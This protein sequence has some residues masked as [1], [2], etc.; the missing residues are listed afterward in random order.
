MLDSFDAE[1]N[2]QRVLTCSG[3]DNSTGVVTVCNTSCSGAPSQ[4]GAP[5][6][7]DPGYGLDPSSAA[8]VYTPVSGQAGVAGCPAGFN[9]IDEGDKTFFNANGSAAAKLCD[10][11]IVRA[12]HH[13]L[14]LLPCGLSTVR[15]MPPLLITT[16]EVDEAIEMLDAAIGEAR[17]I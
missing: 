2:G 6:S 15:F 11:I 9:V 13:G 8:C 4:T 12:Y 17:G 1:V 3:P 10:D 14:L 7:C 5:I 16:A